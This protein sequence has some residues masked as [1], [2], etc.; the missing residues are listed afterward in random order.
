LTWGANGL[1]VGLDPG[2]ACCAF[3]K[4]FVYVFDQ[5]LS[6]KFM[7]FVWVLMEFFLLLQG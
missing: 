6:I 7:G 5:L 4:M 3:K 2:L 1:L